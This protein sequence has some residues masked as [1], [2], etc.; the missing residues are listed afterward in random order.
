MLSRIKKLENVDMTSI[1]LEVNADFA[2]TMNKII[3][4]SYVQMMHDRRSIENE[5]V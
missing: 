5:E 2:R 3:L 1:I 4:N